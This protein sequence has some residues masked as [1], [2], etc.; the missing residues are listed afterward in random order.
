[1]GNRGTPPNGMGRAPALALLLLA[2]LVAEVLPGWTRTSVLFVYLTE[3]GTWG[4]GAL[5]VRA[6]VRRWNGGWPSLLLM[7]LALAAAEELLIQQTS[8]APL[9]GL[10]KADYGRVAGVNWVYLLWALGFES[11]W[12]VVLPV[13]LVELIFPERRSQ[14]WIGARGAAVT[15]LVFLAACFVAWA[16]WTRYARVKVFHMAPY[17]PPLAALLAG[18]ALIAAL[19]LT[20]FLARGWGRAEVRDA[21]RRAPSPWLVGVA[22]TV[23]AAPW[24]AL[25]L[26]AYD[27]LPR[28][29]WPVPVAGGLAWAALTLALFRRWTGAADW[30][31]SHRFAVVFGGILGSM[32]AGYLVFAI[33]R[34]LQI[35]WIGKTVLDAA[36]LVLLVAL[37]VRTARRS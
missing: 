33:G 17:A 19:V 13:R 18:A 6:L 2:P 16:S 27:A 34:A 11:V 5:L 32:A 30:R 1:M 26:V 35:D 23:L 20:A 24:C 36:A 22:T 28:L 9:A 7:G 12:V 31:D 15:G 37:G 14:T 21:A 25:V 8:L 10:A 3:I 4:C 29:A